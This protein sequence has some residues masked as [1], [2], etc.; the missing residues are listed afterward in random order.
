LEAGRLINERMISV[1]RETL[2]QLSTWMGFVGII[3]IIGG[4]FS[5]LAGLFAFVIGAIPGIITI[6]L[7]VKLRSAK[8]SADAMLERTSPEESMEHFNMFAANLNTYFKIQG[9]LII[10]S[11][12]L[13]IVGMLFGLIAGYSLYRFQ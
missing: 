8:Q 10:I 11:F 6:I 4:V 1:N 3:T 13:A 5:A 12:A 7:G 2:K 9:I